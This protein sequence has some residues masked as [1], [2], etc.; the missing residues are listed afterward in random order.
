MNINF[1]KFAEL[2]ELELE[3]FISDMFTGTGYAIN[4]KNDADYEKAKAICDDVY[5][6]DNV[7]IERIFA[8][9]LKNS[10]PIVVTDPE[11]KDHDFTLDMLE[12]GLDTLLEKAPEVF[13]DYI[14]CNNDMGS[15]MALIDCCI[16]G[17]V[18][19]G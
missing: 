17:E 7:Y 12:N 19:Y 13:R 14:H 3:D 2:C 9:M 11:G 5:G 6:K 1:R 8:Y 15:G 4:A 18:V 10:M 16:F